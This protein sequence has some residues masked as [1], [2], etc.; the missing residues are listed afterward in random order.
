MFPSNDLYLLASL[1][2]YC[3]SVFLQIIACFFL[4]FETYF[5][6]SLIWNRRW[7]GLSSTFFLSFFSLPT[8]L[9]A[10]S[11]FFFVT[12][13]FCLRSFFSFSFLLSSRL[14]YCLSFLRSFFF[15]FFCILTHILTV[16]LGFYN[17]IIYFLFFFFAYTF[18][19]SVSLSFSHSPLNSFFF[20][21]P[22]FCAFEMTIS[23]FLFFYYDLSSKKIIIY[24][25]CN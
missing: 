7:G 16:S 22:K 19:L 2:F 15:A 23:F 21:S 8:Q 13:V 18:L 3:Y 20:K 14:P 6:L 12:L 9:L 17:L 1:V 5:S 4:T 11:F 24:W 25:K 10:S